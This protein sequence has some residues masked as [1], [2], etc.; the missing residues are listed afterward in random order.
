MEYKTYSKCI[1]MQLTYTDDTEQRCK[2][3][4]TKSH[5]FYF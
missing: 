3:E 5:R 1:Q 4:A 2:E